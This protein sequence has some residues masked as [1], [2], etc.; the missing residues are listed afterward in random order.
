[1][2]KVTG[3]LEYT[4]ELPQRR[5]PAERIKDWFEIYLD[6]PEEKIRT[7]GGR[8]MDCGVPFCH[9]GC[10]LPHIIPD[11]NDLV[12]RGRV[13]AGY[14]RAS[15]HHQADREE[16]HRSRVRGRLDPSGKTRAADRETGGCDRLGA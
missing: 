12:Y 6:F 11:W 1:M 7:Q 14:Q 2:G 10:P 5:P 9:T 16:H 15:G 4:R 13:R 3:F 8:C